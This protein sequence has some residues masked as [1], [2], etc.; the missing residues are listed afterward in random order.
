MLLGVAAL[1]QC[2]SH[3]CGAEPVANTEELLTSLTHEPSLAAAEQ[4]KGNAPA[5]KE[6]KELLSLLQIAM[7]YLWRYVESA[8]QADVFVDYGGLHLLLSTIYAPYPALSSVQ[9]LACGVL[10]RIATYLPH[11]TVLI[12]LETPV[13]LFNIAAEEGMPLHVRLVALQCL[14]HLVT[15]D[16]AAVVRQVSM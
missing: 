4:Q 13:R 3:G 5:P 12:G 9:H 8:A 6:P 14:A 2:D 15:L 1:T 16:E 7:G 11:A 10:W